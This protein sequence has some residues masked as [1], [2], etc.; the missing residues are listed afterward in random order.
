MIKITR[1]PMLRDV[2]RG[3]KIYIDDI[4]RGEIQIDDTKEFE[5]ENGIHVVCAKLDWCR[6][7]ELRVEVNDSVVELEVGNSL[8][9]WRFWLMSF[10]MTVGRDQYLFLREKESTDTSPKKV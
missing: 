6:S 8:R 1:G 9:G 4:Y 7:N 3:Y 5:V 2:L 10:Y